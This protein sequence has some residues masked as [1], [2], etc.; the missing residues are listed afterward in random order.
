M[1]VLFLFL[2]LTPPLPPSSLLV[3]V[4]L[5]FAAAAAAAAAAN[6]HVILFSLIDIPVLSSNAQ[7]RQGFHQLFLFISLLFIPVVVF[8]YP[9]VIFRN[10]LT[11]R[12]FMNFFFFLSL[13]L[14]D[15]FCGYPRPSK[16][17]S[18]VGGY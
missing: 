17:C 2:F 9:L 11:D 3:L 13:S 1:F 5:L 4:L 15:I 18:T 16:F 6:A 12:A 14:F 7:Y 10:M 8:F